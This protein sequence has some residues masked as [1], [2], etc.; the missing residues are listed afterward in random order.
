M[1]VTGD[2][3]ERRRE[4]GQLAALR[5]EHL[6]THRLQDLRVEEREQDDAEHA[7]GNHLAITIRTAAGESS[8]NAANIVSPS[9]V[10]FAPRMYGRT[11]STL[12]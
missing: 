5:P 12:T 1:I 7:R 4:H 6:G 2:Q 9:V 11:W 10:M 3:E 8:A